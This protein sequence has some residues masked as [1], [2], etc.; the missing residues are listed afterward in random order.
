MKKTELKQIIKEELKKV[1][2]AKFKF[3]KNKWSVHGDYLYVQF[4]NSK[5]AEDAVKWIR[6]LG[7][8]AKLI[9]DLNKIMININDVCTYY[10]NN[11]L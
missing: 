11:H 8:D 3:T 4:N 5:E 9:K 7:D 6:N 2:E 1:F 10:L